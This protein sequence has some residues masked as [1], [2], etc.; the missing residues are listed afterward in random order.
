MAY[1]KQT[2]GSMYIYEATQA[3]PIYTTSVYHAVI[4]LSEGAM[5]GHFTFTASAVG[6]IADT[7]D[8]GG[9]LRCTDVAHGLTTGQYITLNG[10]GDVAHN[11]VTGVTVIDENTFDCDDIAYNSID[12]TGYWQRGSSLTVASGNGGEYSIAYR[13]CG[14]V[15]TA[16]K[17]FKGEVYVNTTP[18]DE[19]ADEKLFNNTGYNAVGT[20]GFATLKSG[21][22]IW[23]AIE[24]TTDATDFEMRHGNLHINK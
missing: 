11:G 3:I 23:V 19:F 4:G 7:A 6:E 5:N 16:S 20:G 9:V 1:I 22:V 8:N 12:D 18:Q 2:K 24:N 17:D 21:D 15:G 14:K 10:M 13:I